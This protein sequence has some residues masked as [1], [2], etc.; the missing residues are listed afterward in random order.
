MRSQ[1]GSAGGYA[2]ASPP[3]KIS[4]IRAVDGLLAEVHRLRPHETESD[5]DAQH[6]PE[7]RV[8]VRA[9]LRRV[10]DQTSLAQVLTGR[11]PAHVRR[12]VDSPDA[13][14]PR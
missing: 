7:L 12:M 2:L 1:P 10:L 5:G 4:I 11:L 3:D 8:A 9:S 14:L 13:W 6:F